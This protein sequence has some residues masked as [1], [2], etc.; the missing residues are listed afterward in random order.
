MNMVVDKTG[1]C[2]D[3]PNMTREELSKQLYQEVSYYNEDLMDLCQI[4]VKQVPRKYI[5]RIISKMYRVRKTTT[6]KT[7]V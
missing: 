5:Y 7:E 3:F 2:M 4:L 1:V 6:D